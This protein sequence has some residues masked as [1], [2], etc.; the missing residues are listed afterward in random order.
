MIPD[1]GGI[2]WMAMT[3]IAV[4]VSIVLF[5]VYRYVVEPPIAREMT[6]AKW[7]AGA[8]AFIQDETG[9]N[10]MVSDKK[11]PEGVVHYKKR[12]WFLIAK[13]NVQQEE[14]F[15]PKKRKSENQDSAEHPLKRLQRERKR[16]EEQEKTEEIILHTPILR[17]LN[18]QV[19]FGSVDSVALSSLTTI[20]HADLKKVRELAP[21]MYQ[22]TQLDSLWTNARI[23]VMKMMG[24]FW[25]FG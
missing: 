9:V 4:V 13:K 16:R 19:F 10:F 24:M 11:L 21:K 20:A 12:G 14:Q 5:I 25:V 1:F 23:E 3:L 8:P 2:F 7:S 22:K 18:K 6:K 15:N 17:G